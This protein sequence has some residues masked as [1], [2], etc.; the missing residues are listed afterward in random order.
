MKKRMISAL[1]ILITVWSMFVIT[2]NAEQTVS[3]NRDSINLYINQSYQLSVSGTTDEVTFHSSDTKIAD[4]SGDGTVTAHALGTAVITAV[5][6]D[7][8]SAG[9]SVNVLK[10]VSP[11]EMQINAQNITLKEGESFT[12][13]TVVFPEE[14]TDKSVH[15]VSSDTSIVRVDSNG[16]MRAFKAGVAVITAESS[17]A[18]VSQKCIV[19]VNP[20]E[21]ESTFNISLNGSLYAISGEKKNNMIVEL[22]NSEIY[23][24][25]QT[26]E[27]GLF[28]FED[29][30]Q[31]N[32][33]LAV[34]KTAKDRAPVSKT[35]ISTGAYHMTIS[36]IMNG[37]ELVVLYQ[38]TVAADT[39]LKDVRLEKSAV[40]L[41]C[42]ETYD[43]NYYAVPSS[44]GVPTM[45][46]TST[47]ESIA[48]VDV[49]GR[50]TAVSEGKVNIVFS[51]PDGSISKSCV[52]TVTGVNSNTYSWIIILLESVII[53][54]IV[55][56]FTAQYHRYIKK[57]EKE[58]FAFDEDDED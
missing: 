44:V 16:Y 10:G 53:L 5:T 30:P 26:D 56:I 32:Y 14:T 41:S 8:L 23:Q 49:D 17:S 47:D 55:L 15:Y 27:N 9:C 24:R 51:T 38:E 37:S 39:E 19:K 50:I 54:M 52:V 35:Q 48:T 6:N 2:V 36:C 4:V 3:M 21:G 42:G 45:S 12:L 29:I 25:S 18:A 11:K 20:R 31:G 43:M 22:R 13:E 58:E 1:M 40:T 33:S 57:K 34:Y 28:S 46:G 7:G